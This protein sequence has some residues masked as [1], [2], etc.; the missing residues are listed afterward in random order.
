MANLPLP[1]PAS[2]QAGNLITGALWNANVFN[3]LTYLLNPPIF[4]ATQST[5][6]TAS[7]GAWFVVGFDTEQ[8]DTYNG[9]STTTNNSRY[10]C[11]QAGY[12]DVCGVAVA[13]ANATGV[14]AARISLNGGANPV[15]GASCMVATAGSSSFTGICTPVR[16]IYLNL[17]DYIELGLY[18]TSGGNLVTGVAADLASA[19][20]VA[21]RHA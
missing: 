5:T 15:A 7:N 18:Q 10:V 13:G 16:T 2:E 8:V 19:L 20:Y 1:V 11:Q 17:N 4:V 21:F 6:Q 12:Y 14:R 9:H 3:G